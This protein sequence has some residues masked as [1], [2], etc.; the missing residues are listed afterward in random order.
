MKVKLFIVLLFTINFFHAQDIDNDGVLD[1]DDACPT[2]FGYAS[3]IPSKNGC[4]KQDCKK[5]EEERQARLKIF[6]DESKHVDYNKL[7]EKIIDDIDLKL[8]T[9]DNVIIF[10]KI[11]TLT[12][13]TGSAYYCP[14][15]YNFESPVFSTDDLLTEETSKKLYNKIPKNIIFAKRIFGE[16]AGIEFENEPILNNISKKVKIFYG[17]EKDAIIYPKHKKIQ[18]KINRY[19]GLLL[20]IIK[21]DFENK[22]EVRKV[23]TDSDFRNIKTFLNTYQYIDNHWILI[24]TKTR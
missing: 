1:E 18:T 17:I 12:C 10:N 2:V 16:A 23:Y 7:V 6:Q 8:F 3:D 21:N 22:V 24:E 5:L 20:S 15:N 13:G 14:V 19:N 11:T 9:S 4:M